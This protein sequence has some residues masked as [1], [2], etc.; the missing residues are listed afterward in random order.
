MG[1]SRDERS[2]SRRSDR[3]VDRRRFIAGGGGLAGAVLLGACSTSTPKSVN[4]PTTK[5]S[6]FPLGAAA[7]AEDKPVAIT[8]WH[9]MQSANLTALQN[10]TSAFNSSQP[11][12]T[13]S[14]VNQDSY[15]DTLTL[16]TAAL[17]GGTLP[18]VV[19][20]ETADLQL[21]IDSQSIVSAQAAIDA[22]NYD[23]SD[24]LASTVD[25]FKV[26]GVIWAMPFNI[27][28]QVLYFDAKAF[29]RAGLD[30]STPPTTL[31]DLQSAAQKIVS[32]GT[33]KYGMSLK[34]SP[35]T[36]EEWLAMAGQPLLNNGN[37][38]T[39]RATSV[40]FDGSEGR[41]IASY[42]EEMY[43]TKLAQPTS[44][45]TYDNLFAIANRI[46]PMTLET[47]AALGTVV[48]LLS[49]YPQ[50]KLGVG[51]MPGPSATGG[52]FVGGAG[53]Y[54]VSKSSD[55]RQDAAWQ[56]IKYLV[57][58]AQQASWAAASGYIPV[59]KSATSQSV[60]QTRWSQIPEFKVA[61]DQILASPQSAATAGPVCGSQAQ[62]DDAVED[63]LT[64]IS[65]GTSA[66]AA[67]AQ[68]ASTAD[69]AISSY[70]NRL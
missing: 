5:S 25:Y 7:K 18:D 45:T 11:D 66:V 39:A 61:Y 67:L 31:A 47:S 22:D 37:G 60:L 3:T 2:Q 30:P 52:V 23:L 20:M 53:L 16:Y 32:S 13:V 35:S 36:F 1:A 28:S 58:P 15:T 8:V 63:G 12:V 4:V 24:F 14:L 70:D 68:A 54:M 56:Y 55:E 44:A 41:S 62:V 40:V 46:A 29:T 49:G 57:E 64:A 69:Q 19:Q 26:G 33:E 65:T 6:T 50:V 10:M 21:M 48:G 9:S 59:R 51:P 17:S 42:Y 38:R 43:S 34:L 27:S